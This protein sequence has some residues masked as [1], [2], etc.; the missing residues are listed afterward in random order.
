MLFYN[1]F[2]DVICYMFTCKHLKILTQVE[3]VENRQKIGRKII[4]EGQGQTVT[5]LNKRNLFQAIITIILFI[6]SNQNG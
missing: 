5:A 4:P 3:Q 2:Q 6:V 1:N